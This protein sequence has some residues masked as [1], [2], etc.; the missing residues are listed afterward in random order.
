M[1][2]SSVHPSSL[3]RCKKKN[4]ENPISKKKKTERGKER[5]EKKM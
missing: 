3:I 2:N 5:R 4:K 1:K